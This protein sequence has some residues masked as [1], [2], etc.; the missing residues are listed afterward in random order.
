MR[1]KEAWLRVNPDDKAYLEWANGEEHS[2]VSRICIRPVDATEES[3]LYEIMPGL[4]AEG[5]IRLRKIATLKEL[6]QNV[7]FSYSFLCPFC[8]FQSA[9]RKSYGR[10]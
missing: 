7:L 8:D 4:T 2:S 3:P 1:S 10:R 9:L 6:Q 5:F